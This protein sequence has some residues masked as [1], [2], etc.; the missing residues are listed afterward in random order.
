MPVWCDQSLNYSLHF[1]Q[2]Q[3]INW[4]PIKKFKWEI[5][6]IRCNIIWVEFDRELGKFVLDNISDLN[7]YKNG[8][9]K[10]DKEIRFV[11]LIE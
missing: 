1:D 10:E 6:Q 7:E 5:Q 2:W 9:N 8:Y 4:I 3:L 11:C